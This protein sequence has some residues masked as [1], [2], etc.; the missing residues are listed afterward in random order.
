MEKRGIKSYV[1]RQGR[2]SQAQQQ[3]YREQKE[4][5][6]LPYEEK[7]LD[8]TETFPGLDQV[9]LEIGFGMGDATHQIAFENRD[10]GYIGVE[11]HKPGVGKLL[12]QITK[13][14][15]TNIRIIEHDACEVVDRMISPASLAGVHIFFPDPWPKKK[16]HKRRLIQEPFVT[17]L[18][19]RLKPGG[20]FY[21]ATDW[22]DYADQMLEVLS[23]NSLLENGF[24][25]FADHQS[26]RPLTNFEQKGLKKSHE[27]H[28]VFFVKK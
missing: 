26:W 19:K 20:Y 23:A 15:L 18:A 6:S 13:R 25:G 8:F 27:I 11:V 24:S 14:E 2:M 9:V 12:D 28:E 7:A 22:D 17:E 10:K 16:H 4:K 21:A 3:A 5:W 1:I